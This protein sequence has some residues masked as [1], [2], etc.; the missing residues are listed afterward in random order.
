MSGQFQAIWNFLS[1]NPGSD[2][3][4]ILRHL[5]SLGFANETTSTINS[6]LYR[7]LKYFYWSSPS[8][9]SQRNWYIKDYDNTPIRYTP[10]KRKK[11]EIFDALEL[12]PWQRR[13]Y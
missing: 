1:E 2:K 4:E 6:F 7:N 9:S 12:Y 3:R 8:G 5:Q 13:A 10:P 11:E